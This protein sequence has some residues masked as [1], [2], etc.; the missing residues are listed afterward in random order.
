MIPPDRRE[1]EPYRRR[2]GFAARSE[3]PPY[4]QASKI[5][6]QRRNGLLT[7]SLS[8]R[9]GQAGSLDA[10]L[11][12]AAPHLRGVAG[13]QG[14]TSQPW[15]HC[16]SP[17]AC[18]DTLLGGPVPLHDKAM[19]VP[20]GA[21]ARTPMPD[22]Y[23]RAVLKKYHVPDGPR[24]PAMRTAKA[25]EA[26]ILAW[27]GDY[28]TP[29]GVSFSGSFAKGTAVSTGT[30]I[31]LFISFRR[32][33][34]TLAN[35]YDAVFD[36]ARTRGWRPRRQNVSI[37]IKLGDMDVDLVPGRVHDGQKN[38]HSLYVNKTGTWQQTNV[39]QH[40]ALVSKSNR[41]E[42]IR[43][44]KVWRDLHRVDFPSIYL[45]LTA[46]DALFRRPIGDVAANII[47]TLDHIASALPTTRIVDPV[48][49][50]NIIS[51]MLTALEKQAVVRA[52]TA[53]RGQKTWNKVIW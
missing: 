22:R 13:K 1:V 32:E 40:I 8:S 48:N 38:W 44:L 19:A 24:S 49:T 37:G 43:A 46:L 23:I 27:A 20:N 2:I 21:F 17:V 47:H 30:D 50:S 5:A 39:D 28:L 42:E 14:G 12:L 6:G 34:G 33:T 18:G 31:D 10:A 4:K 35:I 3:N 9:R 15:P 52:A 16:L 25:V 45:E 41:T 36:F 26:E 7:G 53:A 29:K 11:L 51:G